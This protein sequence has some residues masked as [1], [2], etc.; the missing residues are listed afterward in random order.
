MPDVKT[1][2]CTALHK[3]KSSTPNIIL[4]TALSCLLDLSNDISFISDV[5]VA[6]PILGHTNII[7]ADW[8]NHV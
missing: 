2:P 3:G 5:M 8:L 7:H 4:N 1:T 6:A